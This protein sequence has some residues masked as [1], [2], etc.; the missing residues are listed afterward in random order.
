MEQLHALSPR[1]DDFRKAGID[2]VAI[3]TEDHET[4]KTGIDN[5]D[6]P[7]EIPLI[8]DAKQVIF[9]SYRCWDDFE[10]QPLHGTFLIDSRDRVR[11]QDIGYEPF[12]D[13]DFL[14]EESQ[15]LLKLP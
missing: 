10:N 6:K 4:L 2:I 14:L 7:V 12:M 15:R 3:S 5:F 1:I 13:V 9:K 8:A 11:W